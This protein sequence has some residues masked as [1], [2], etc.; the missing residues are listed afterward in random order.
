MASLSATNDPEV[1][2]NQDDVISPSN[3]SISDETIKETNLGEVD[4]F[5]GLEQATAS[6]C[7]NGIIF[8]LVDC[9]SSVRSKS[10]S[11]K[12]EKLKAESL[13]S[14]FS[15]IPQKCIIIK[16]EDFLNCRIVNAE[17]KQNPNLLEIISYEVC[18][19]AKKCKKRSRSVLR[20]SPSPLPEDGSIEPL[21]IDK[22]ILASRKYVQRH[23]KVVRMLSDEELL[24][25]KR[26][27]V[28]LN[29]VS[30]KGMALKIFR[31]QIEPFLIEAGIDFELFVSERVGHV[32]DTL[33]ENSLDKW[34]A[35][36]F[37][38]GDGLL[39]E[40][41]NGLLSRDDAHLAIQK[42]IGILPCG[43]GNAVASVTLYY[44]HEFY[45]PLNAAF[46]FAKGLHN[47]SECLDIA[48]LTQGERKSYFF[49][50]IAWGIVADVDTETEVLRRMGEV[51]FI[52]GALWRILKRRIYQADL[53]YLPFDDSSPVEGK[54]PS[55]IEN[56]PS[57]NPSDSLPKE[58]E[59]SPENTSDIVSKPGDNAN[60]SWIQFPG[61]FT[62][63]TLTLL[64]L[65][66]HDL[67]IAPNHEFGKGFFTLTVLPYENIRRRDILRMLGS[68]SDGN[69][70]GLQGIHF[71]KVKAFRF[72]PTF[73]LNGYMTFDGE[74]AQYAEITAELSNYKLC[75]PNLFDKDS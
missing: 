22:I 16:W 34:D 70:D 32:R 38:S 8:R 27:L 69:I 64:P 45:S 46:I 23:Y 3:P 5:P 52:L 9:N 56:I 36:L 14:E 1:Q 50:D 10:F 74:Q 40:G 18:A 71:I 53:S 75:M 4:L 13:K 59:I 24:A 33:R 17:S 63:V 15:D 37:V 44:S 60:S 26:V 43:S 21:W 66:G 55:E 68:M 47:S 49:L 54:S 25:K 57:D 42:P 39:N 62:N 30:G 28:L 48:I 51:R 61:P 58:K 67:F 29:P 73:P 7:E 19:I 12:H 41:I 6:L 72:R 11:V 31:Q 35:F 2:V 20:F 65:I